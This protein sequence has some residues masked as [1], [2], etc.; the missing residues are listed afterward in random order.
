MCSPV[1]FTGEHRFIYTMKLK[2]LILLTS[3][4]IGISG[5][6]QNL[7]RPAALEPGDTIAIISP[8][9]MPDTTFITESEKVLKEW[10]YVPVVGKYAAAEFGT[11]AGNKDQRGED[12]RWAFENDSIKAI[13][14]SRGGYGSIQELCDIPKGFFKQHPKWLIGYSDITAIHSA[15][16][17]DSVMSIHAHMGEYLKDFGGTDTLSMYLRDI[18]EGKEVTYTVKNNHPYNH[19]GECEGILHGGNLSLLT[20]VAGTRIDFLNDGEGIILFVED[21]SE[22]IASVDRMMHRLKMGGIL[23]NLKGLIVGQFTI[24]KPS[25]DHE[26]M[27]DLIKTIVDEYDIPIVYDFPVGHVDNNYPLLEGVK[28]KLKITDDEVTLEM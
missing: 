19:K 27:E 3:I 24:Y 23:D 17:S 8:A 22:R 4:F 2:N 13:L 12:L 25:P 26:T 18:L 6:S 1:I 10:G 14:C 16:Q 28:A 5:F 7:T 15:M 9:S 21:V 11:F 20:S